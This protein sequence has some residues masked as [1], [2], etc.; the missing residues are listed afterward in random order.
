MGELHDDMVRKRG[1]IPYGVRGNALY[2]GRLTRMSC[3]ERS[4]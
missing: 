3:P 1:L 4:G 2:A